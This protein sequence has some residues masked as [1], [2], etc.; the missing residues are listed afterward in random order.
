M[1]CS[2]MSR[3]SEFWRDGED[4]PVGVM[5]I[6]LPDALKTYVDEQVARGG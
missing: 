6:S 5:N 4:Q 2:R 3:F 1:R